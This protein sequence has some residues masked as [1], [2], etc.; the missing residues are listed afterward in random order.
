MKKTFKPSGNL[1]SSIFFA[2][3]K[4]NKAYGSFKRNFSNSYYLHHGTFDLNN[5]NP[6]FYLVCAFTWSSTPE[7]KD[8][9][10]LL[11]DKWSLVVNLFNL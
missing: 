4:Q 6:S 7:G 5:V 1:P 8:Y 2:F 10:S 3:L 11:D 9:W